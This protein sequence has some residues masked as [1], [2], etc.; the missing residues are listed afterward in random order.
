MADSPIGS[1]PVASALY[2]TSLLVIEQQG[3]AM[4]LAGS[5]FRAFA[6]AAAQGKAQE[7]ATYAAAAAQAAGDAE[8]WA[9]HPPNIGGAPGE[10]PTN[11]HWWIYSTSVHDWVDTGV[12]AGPTITIA[13]V[14]AIAPNETPYVTNT[15]TNTDPIFHLFI[16]RGQ[17]GDTGAT[18]PQGVQGIQGERGLNGVAVAADGQY[19]FNVDANGH[20]ILYYNGDTAPNFSIDQNTGHLILTLS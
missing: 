12:D 2:D 11:D 5:L 16:P 13:E 18:G 9:S 8:E 6:V 3:T 4:S 10:T 7:A 1:L 19:A 17:K 14:V 20:L 15:G